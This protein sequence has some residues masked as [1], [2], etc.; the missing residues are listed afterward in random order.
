MNQETWKGIVLKKQGLLEGQSVEKICQH[1]N[2]LQ[3]QFQP[4]VHIGF[5]NRMTKEAFQ[6]ADWQE[7]LTRQWSIRRT[8]HAYLKSEIPLY[9][10]EGR[11][12]DTAY[13]KIEY[14]DELSPKTKQRFHQVIL[15]GLSQ[16][17]LTRD[18]I[19]DL[20]RSEK[21]SLED[22]KR[23]FNAWGGLLRYMVERGEIYQEYGAKR[24]HLLKD[25]QPLPKKKAELEIARRYFS[26]F[27]PVSLADAR[28]YFKENK[29]TVLDWMKQ[30]DLKTI[31]VAGEERFYLGD[32]EEAEL[33]DCLF[34]AGF[35]QL[36]LGYEKKANPFFDPKHIRQIYT[37][38]GIIKPTV[39]YKGRLVATWKR[40]KKDIILD[41]F[42]DLTSS[43]LKELEGYRQAY[44]EKLPWFVRNNRMLQVNN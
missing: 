26:G 16:Q 34:I 17:S 31:Q 44:Q 15:E 28:Y 35:D 20:C 41:V 19:K 5:Q 3:A 36:L 37:L 6:Q 13:L 11:M 30:L 21:I 14:R 39:F 8:V 23:I 9:I 22:E 24:F 10:N 32:L 7:K 12:A 40:D 18:Q 29:S 4:Y 27:G 43:D 1:L 2:G 38:T 42:E 25:F 33:P